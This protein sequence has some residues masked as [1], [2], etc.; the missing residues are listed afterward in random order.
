LSWHFDGQGPVFIQLTAT[1]RADILSGKYPPGTQF[2]TVRSL[3]M[4]AAVNPNTV[5]KAL[6]VLE[7]EGL[8]LSRGTLGRFVTDDRALL[9]Q[10]RNEMQSA[11]MRR[12][13][14]EANK[15]GI[16]KEKFIAFLHESE[17]G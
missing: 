2:P 4:E 15:L 10:K 5:Q 17:E 12:A 6:L 11:Y 7:T 9:E 13:W 14:Q 3:A 1:M 8:V 16:P